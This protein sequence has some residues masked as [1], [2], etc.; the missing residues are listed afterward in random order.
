MKAHPDIIHTVEIIFT[1][2]H[3]RT[4]KFP[5]IFLPKN[6]FKSPRTFLPKMFLEIPN[7]FLKKKKKKNVKKNIYVLPLYI[8]KRGC[9]LC[10][11]RDEKC[12]TKI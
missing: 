9:V 8:E 10:V 5:M 1:K 7:N 11:V 4:L 3:F 6:V 2:S 12:V